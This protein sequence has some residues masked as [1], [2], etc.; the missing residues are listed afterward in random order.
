MKTIQRRKKKSIYPEFYEKYPDIEDIKK[1]VQ[2][3]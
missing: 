3:E 1:R 2:I